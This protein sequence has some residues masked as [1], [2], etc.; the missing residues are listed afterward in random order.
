MLSGCLTVV[1]N[2]HEWWQEGTTVVGGTKPTSSR[3][4]RSLRGTAAALA[5]LLPWSEAK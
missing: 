4:C 2:L 3:Y 1:Q 5:K